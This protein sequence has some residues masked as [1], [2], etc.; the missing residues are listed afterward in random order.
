MGITLLEL[1]EGSPPHFNVHPMR[2]IFIISSRPSPT[3]KD[4]AKWSEDMRDFVGRCL[5]KDC[6]KRSSA[7]DLLKHPW[8]K[9]T[10]K[11]IGSG[12]RGLPII[13]ELITDNWDALE[14]FKAA[15]M[16]DYIEPT[17]NEG[18]EVHNKPDD[19]GATLRR[20]LSGIP[21][22][23]QQLRNAS[24]KRGLTYDGE[25]T[26]IVRPIHRSRESGS[27]VRE[28]KD[29]PQHKRE[30]FETKD[31][32]QNVPTGSSLVRH[33]S[34]S[35]TLYP[36]DTL[37]RKEE[38]SDMQAALKYFRDDVIPPPSEPKISKAAR[39]TIMPDKT[40]IDNGVNDV[41]TESAILNEMIQDCSHASVEL[42]RKV[43]L[44]ISTI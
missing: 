39:D 28:V 10:V 23:R 7:A 17:G 19:G 20:T 26:L 1:C 25:G 43:N 6:D 32:D 9:N 30:Y 16:P 15:K 41:A 35:R 31:V 22:T 12:G 38:A 8:I 3:L 40:L 14:K 36:Q 27:V 24:L 37:V 21:A 4:P 18:T 34:V 13:R 2:A 33:G 11:E 5:V 42:M 44:F 29:L